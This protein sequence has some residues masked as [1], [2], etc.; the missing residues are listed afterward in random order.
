MGVQVGP[1]VSA[2][3]AG[4]DEAWV[5]SAGIRDCLGRNQAVQAG[6]FDWM[7][8]EWRY[9]EGCVVPTAGIFFIVIVLESTV[10]IQSLV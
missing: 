9:H 7:F 8:V 4:F 6:H 10:L 5:D 2:Q 1:T 3:C